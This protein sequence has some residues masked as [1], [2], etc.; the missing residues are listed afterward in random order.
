MCLENCNA[1]G[2]RLFI[3]PILENIFAVRIYLSRQISI[4]PWACLY[5]DHT[6]QPT[7]I[8]NIAI[9]RIIQQTI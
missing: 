6:Y 3:G 8:L 5:K 4:A 7:L 1:G 9:G 2:R